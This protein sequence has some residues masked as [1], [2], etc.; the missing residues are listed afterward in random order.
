ME[1]KEILENLKITEIRIRKK[2]EDAQKK[3]NELALQALAQAKKLE[4]ENDQK[5]KVERDKML[6]IMKKEIDGERERTIKKVNA[7]NEVLKK[8]AHVNQAKKF[9]ISKFEEYIYV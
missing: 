3:G 4:E 2:I 9:F 6:T 8:K 1:P 5:I 7:E